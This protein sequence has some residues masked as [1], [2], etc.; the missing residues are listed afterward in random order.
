MKI[1]THRIDGR[2]C[3]W[4][5]AWL[6]GREQRVQINGRKSS[7]S[8]VISRMPQGYILGQLPFIIYINDFD[9]GI[10][11]NISKF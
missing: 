9:S 4:I 5:K 1:K 11:S 3:S 2:V 7:C 6:N 8:K 10:R